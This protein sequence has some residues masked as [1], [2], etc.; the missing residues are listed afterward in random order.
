[1]LTDQDK[2]VIEA[3][4]FAFGSFNLPPRGEKRAGN[5]AEKGERNSGG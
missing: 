1:M 4:I 3:I 5:Q 2:K